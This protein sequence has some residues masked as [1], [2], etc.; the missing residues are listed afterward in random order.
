[1]SCND[2]LSAVPWLDLAAIGFPSL[3][4]GFVTGFCTGRHGGAR[5]D[6]TRRQHS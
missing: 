1:M 5:A 2:L 4:L 3:L 6:A